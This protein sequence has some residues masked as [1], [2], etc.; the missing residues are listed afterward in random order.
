MESH[1]QLLSSAMKLKT[2]LELHIS[3]VAFSKTI[4]IDGDME[5]KK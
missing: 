3:V 1:V 4:E 2:F 5:K